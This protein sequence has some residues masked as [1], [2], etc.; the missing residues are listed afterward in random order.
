MKLDKTQTGL[1]GEYYVLAQLTARGFIATLTLGNTK[2]VDILVTNHE[3]NK[4]FKVE[5]KTTSNAAKNAALFTNK[6]AYHWTMGM[7]HENI[8]DNNLIYC[9]VIIEDVNTLPLFF[10]VPS[11][12]VAEYVKW[13]HDYWLS[14]RTEKVVETN[15][16]QYRI[17]IDDPKNYL[18]NWEIFR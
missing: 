14:T 7:K 5:V 1:A 13:Q 4:L 11:N 8:K 6:K 3:I 18:N 2:G 10:L 9:F 15:M 16:R 17:E 12:D